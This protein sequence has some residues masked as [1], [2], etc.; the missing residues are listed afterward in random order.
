MIYETMKKILCMM[1]NQIILAHINK[2]FNEIKKLSDGKYRF[3][4][5]TNSRVEKM[6]Y[7]FDF[8]NKIK[9]T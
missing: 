3:I 6:R 9:S 1:R 4:M 2:I 8:L 5:I 7:T